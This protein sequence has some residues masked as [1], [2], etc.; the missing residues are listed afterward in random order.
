MTAVTLSN[1]VSIATTQLRAFTSM[2]WDIWHG[3]V[4]PNV[5]Y[6]EYAFGV[7]AK[8]ADQVLPVLQR[9]ATAF[10][11]IKAQITSTTAQ[12]NRVVCE[13]TWEGTHTGQ[14]LGPTGPVRPTGIHGTVHA[15]EIFIFEGE[16][17][18]AMHHYFDALELLRQLGL[19]PA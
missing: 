9:W 11:D 3:L 17:I 10:P 8:G 16:R 14:F 5:E 1:E 15:V 7:H 19:A 18:S 12:D 6:H 13:I 2:Q 4:T